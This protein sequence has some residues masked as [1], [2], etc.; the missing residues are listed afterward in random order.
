MGNRYWL[1]M[2]A[3]LVAAIAIVAWAASYIGTGSAEKEFQKT[4]DA[5]KQ[6]HSFRAA[7]SGAGNP[8]TTRQH[9]ELLWEVDCSRN[10]AHLQQH[11]TVSCTDPP[12]CSQQGDMRREELDWAVY[13]YDRQND[14][15]WAASRYSSG[16]QSKSMCGRLAE[17]ADSNVLPPIATMI[18]RGILQKGD[19]KTVNGVRCREWLVT[20]RGGPSRLEHDT[21]CLGLEDHLPYEMTVD[22]DHS[23][24]SFSDYNTPIEFDLPAE[25]VRATSTN[26][27]N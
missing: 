6:V 18:K 20:L 21:V 9:N 19:K 16:N 7:Y 17:G 13:A 4:L 1:W 12:D 23:R 14:G 15:S 11:F 26:G 8:F 24:T 27:S 22:W 2:G 3:R 5:M 25:V 10:I